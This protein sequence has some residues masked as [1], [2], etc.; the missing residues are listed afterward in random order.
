M[1]E[2]VLETINNSQESWRIRND[3]ATITENN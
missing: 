1:V 2:K 3:A